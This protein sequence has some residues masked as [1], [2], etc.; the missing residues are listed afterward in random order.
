M[1][2]MEEDGKVDQGTAGK[3]NVSGNSVP[4]VPTAP[5]DAG[6]NENSPFLGKLVPQ[7]PSIPLGT[8]SLETDAELQKSIA[9]LS[10]LKQPTTQKPQTPLTVGSE[11]LTS[12]DLLH[13]GNVISLLQEEAQ[14]ESGIQA[15]KTT[16][17]AKA[18][19]PTERSIREIGLEPRR[20]DNINPADYQ[21]T[22]PAGGLS[23]IRT[24]ASDMSE[25][26]RKRGETLAT[27]VNAEQTEARG[28]GASEQG[29]E[30]EKRKNILLLSGT[31][32]LL[33][34][35][36]GAIIGVMLLLREPDALPIRV[37]IVP[38]NHVESLSI[39]SGTNL[40]KSLAGLRTKASLNLGEL[41]EIAI[42][43][44]GIRLSAE[45]T[46]LALG[47][48]SSLARNASDIMVGV[49][50]YNRNQP[51]ILVR[52]S[53]YD[54]AFEGMLA[55]EPVIGESLGVFFA[56]S[57]GTIPVLKFSDR[58]FQNLDAR[59]SQPEWRVVYAFPEKN[60]L[61]ITTNES[62]VKEVVTRLTLQGASGQ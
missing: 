17:L 1:T 38:V 57:S 15:L 36:I 42:Y 49:H 52:V 2:A 24:Y 29:G 43:E 60:L 27:I 4:D 8:P 18:D 58:V 56:P 31:G 47:A 3:P 61:L 59:E 11:K 22:K 23:N 35:G 12:A 26:I 53:A 39:E 54:R 5:K 50:A 55:W 7:K 28:R 46:L 48:P 33:L 44:N 51:F 10:A 14:K 37:S 21:P 45:E 41:E 34:V 9:A 6:M 19:T 20:T 25:E 30:Q 40:A 62:T 32:A 13:G 16:K